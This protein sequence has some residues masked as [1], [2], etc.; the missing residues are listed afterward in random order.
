MKKESK[1][2]KLRSMRIEV[3]D[4][5]YSLHAHHEP[6]A[7]AKKNPWSGMDHKP[8]ETVHE[9]GESLMNKIGELVAAHEGKEMGG[10]KKSPKPAGTNMLKGRA[11]DSDG[12]EDGY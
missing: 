4:N 3:A 9:D 11:K 7:N 8:D 10:K 12:D 2:G 6:S 1:K 5:G